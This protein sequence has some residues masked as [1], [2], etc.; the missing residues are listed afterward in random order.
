MAGS[1]LSLT[2]GCLGDTT[3]RGDSNDED[4]SDDDVNLAEMTMTLVSIDDD[5]DSL[6]F[7]IEVL[8]TQ[9]TGTNFPTMEIAVTNTGD[10]TASWFYGGSSTDI[11]FP[12]GIG[13]DPGGLVSG[14]DSNVEA[15]LVDVDDGCARVEYF[16]RD[17]AQMEAGLDAGDTYDETYGIAGSDSSL[18][19]VCP[20]V[21]TYR[22][23]FSYDDHG[24]WGFEIELS[25]E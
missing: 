14:R 16:D 1:G 7:E 10:E 18:E 23:E 15:Q 25:N 21:G 9:L 8:E 11:P 24:S 19:G 4:D 22:F 6:S 5:L 13:S 3:E 12:Q 2:A 20:D 17:D